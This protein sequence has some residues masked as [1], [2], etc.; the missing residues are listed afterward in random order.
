MRR[1]I[2]R[3]ASLSG[4]GIV[5]I[6]RE[7]KNVFERRTPI[8]PVHVRELLDRK[9]VKKIIVQPSTIRC[10][11]DVEFKDAGAVINEDLSEAGT[12]I[13]V[14]EVPAQ[15]L[16]DDRTYM[17]FSH[18]IKAQAYNM[19]LLDT[20]IAKNIR[21]ID[22]EKIIGPDG[23]VVKF[24]PHAGY[25]GMIDTL[26]AVGQALLLRGYATPFLHT[27]LAKEYRSLAMAREDLLKTGELIRK[28][29]LPEAVC[30]LVFAVTGSGSV[31]LAVQQ[32]LHCL[33]CKYVEVDDLPRL[34]NRRSKD[35]HHIYVT[36]VR[37]RDMAKPKDPTK[38]FETQHYYSN[39]QDYEGCFHERV[40][41][42]VHVLV[43]GHYWEPRFPRLLTIQQAQALQRVDRFPLLCLGDITCDIGGSI[44]FFVKSTSIQ[45]PFYAYDIMKEKVRELHDY[46]G[47][48][49]LILGVDH[50]PAEF[51]CE[52]STDF[53]HGLAPLLGTVANAPDG[54][55]EEQKKALGEMLFNATVTSHRQLTE[56]F[57]Y[58]D[59]L[60][61]K[62]EAKLDKKRRI[63]VLG[64]GM[65]AGPCIEQLLDKQNTLTLVDASQRALDTL[66]RGFATRGT[67]PGLNAEENYDVRTSVAD[68]S[69]IDEYM[70]NEIK[71]SDLV[72]S[73]LPAPMHPTIA[74]CAIAHKVPMIT[75]SYVSPGMEALRSK[76]EESGTY[77]VNELGL[78]PGIDIM[79]SAEIMDR[80]RRDGGKI[81]KYVS[82][83][84][85]LP[86]PEN[87]NCPLGYKFSWFPRGVL[88]AAK[89]PSRFC[90][91]GQWH[92]VDGSQ[93]F[94]HAMPITAFRGM[95]LYWVPN[96]DAEKYS[97]VYDIPEADTVIRGTIRYSS[98]APVMRALLPLGFLDEERPIEALKKGTTEVA[99]WRSIVA[100]LLDCDSIGEVEEKLIRRLGEIIRANRKRQSAPSY[101][102]L[103]RGNVTGN[104]FPSPT[105]AVEQ[106]IT[107]VLD[108][109][110]SLQLLDEAHIAPKTASGLILD[111]L[112]KTML[113][114]M[115]YSSHERDFIIM[116]HRI[117]AH[118][119]STNR[120]RVYTA[121]LTRRGE[122]DIRSATA[123]TVGAP[124]GITAQLALSG[125]LRGK[126]GLLIPTDPDIYKPVLEQLAA[127]GI[128]MHEKVEDA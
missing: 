13:A 69:K 97:K 98:F 46:D 34:H 103:L 125:A 29:G 79:T 92:D 86:A 33:P 81:T 22:Y 76:A 5:A 24:G 72:V 114:F 90:V 18:T 116:M 77:V 10:F 9:Q 101:Q 20:I 111:S 19:P 63:L 14:K 99:S 94:N 56:K 45:N 35:R 78:D 124:V 100:Q 28:Y 60:R 112:C 82:L 25:A 119:P 64:G 49:V 59:V 73:M 126:K 71:R 30:P 51:P 4:N 83:C 127:M 3:C 93:L 95:D 21:L 23:R 87:S 43:T 37:A 110:K 48:G 122:S 39:P 27:S 89:R 88:T 12:I 91:G 6:R 32:M 68:A 85:A 105:E 38:R 2:T 42:Y 96:G 53:G 50:L 61:K 102:A 109:F 41:P 26:H 17:F 115:T 75:A 47:T 1:T 52:A 104:N 70:E 117:T 15:L 113:D 65:V 40:A 67:K 106:E 118:F 120:T 58:I 108:A 31:S 80:I 74:E 11:S 84:G 62:N 66:V 128:T 8:A 121:T 16:L 107:S 44:E 7:D 57:H 36:V 54:P 123:I 55:L